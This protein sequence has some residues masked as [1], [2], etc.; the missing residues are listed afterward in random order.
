M[1]E[2]GEGR[3]S[4]RGAAD[5]PGGQRGPFL[6]RAWKGKG[7]T[8]GGREQTEGC[9]AELMSFPCR[10]LISLQTPDQPL[11]AHTASWNPRVW[12]SVLRMGQGAH[13]SRQLCRGGDTVPH[14]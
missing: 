7:V 11:T 4:W 2:V 13:V 3:Q 6:R 14:C 12:D 1:V 8:H 10:V 5:R 9:L